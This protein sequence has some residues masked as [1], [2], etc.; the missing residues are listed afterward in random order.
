MLILNYRAAGFLGSHFVTACSKEGHQVI[1]LD[2][3]V[4]GDPAN[5]K[6]LESNSNFENDG[7]GCFRVH[8]GRRTARLYPAF[9]LTCQP[10]PASPAW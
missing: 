2:N 6:H 8:P 7:T 3:F 1:G 5:L 4:T 10:N 9:R